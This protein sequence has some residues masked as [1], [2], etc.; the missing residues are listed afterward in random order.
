MDERLQFV[1]RRLRTM[2]ALRNAPTLV[3]VQHGAGRPHGLGRPTNAVRGGN[4]HGSA[5]GSFLV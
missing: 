2:K 4:R 1:A 3:K 5:Y